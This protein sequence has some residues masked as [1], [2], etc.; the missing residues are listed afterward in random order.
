[1]STPVPGGSPDLPTDDYC[2]KCNGLMQPSKAIQETYTGVPD[3]PGAHVVTVSAG[4][5]GRLIDC[6]KCEACGWSV[7]R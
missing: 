4:G 6:M 7:T 2:R 3:F 5:P 1:M